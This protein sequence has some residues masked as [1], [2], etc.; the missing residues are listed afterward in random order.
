MQAARLQALESFRTGDT[1]ILLAT[2]VA[3]RGLDI[4]GVQA[5]V[6]YDCPKTLA[7]YLHRVG[8]TARAGAK[9][10]SISLVEDQDRS[11]M[12]E[13][14][15]HANS[16]L[17][18]RELPNRVIKSWREKVEGLAR[19][20]EDVL[21]VCVFFC[22]LFA[23]DSCFVFWC[24]AQGSTSRRDCPEHRLKNRPRNSQ[25]VRAVGT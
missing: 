7:T 1:Q 16:R 14:V 2:D 4:L 21:M 13:V 22:F 8:R 19:S 24:S 20:V 3:A 5:V 10:L 23:L 12:K 11:L 18:K 9:G 25:I 17:E 15:K 6:N